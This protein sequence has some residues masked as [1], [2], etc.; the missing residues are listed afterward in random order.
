M[1]FAGKF[2]D[3]PGK[4][5]ERGLLTIGKREPANAIATMCENYLCNRVVLDRLDRGRV[6]R[7]ANLV[8]YESTPGRMG[9]V[10]QSRPRS[11]IQRAPG[12]ATLVL[13]AH[14][15]IARAPGPVSVR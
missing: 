3:N 10:P 2:A 14:T 9:T 6:L 1:P 15:R 4:K 8:N 13:L 5:L 7:S 11:R 12:R